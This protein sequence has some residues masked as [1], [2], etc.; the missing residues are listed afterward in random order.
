[1][2]TLSYEAWYPLVYDTKT[3]KW[4]QYIPASGSWKVLIL[5]P[6]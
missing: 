4:Y 2:G 5:H 6:R 1:M 3:D